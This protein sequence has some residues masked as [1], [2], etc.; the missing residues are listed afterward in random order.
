MSLW[1]EVVVL[2]D[3]SFFKSV[4]FIH[5]QVSASNIYI[6]CQTSGAKHGTEGLIIENL[7]ISI[8]GGLD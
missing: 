4:P 8:Q 3:L 1:F 5:L 6:Y 2:K 7:N